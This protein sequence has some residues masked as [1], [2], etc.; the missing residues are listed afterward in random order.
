MKAKHTDKRRGAK[1]AELTQSNLSPDFIS[2]FLRVEM[3]SGRG[4]AFAYR[5]FKF[6]W[7]QGAM[8]PGMDNAMTRRRLPH[9]FSYNN[10]LSRTRSVVQSLRASAALR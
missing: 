10:I 4:S 3:E 8:I 9:G 5:R 2:W 1:N 7:Q 6:A